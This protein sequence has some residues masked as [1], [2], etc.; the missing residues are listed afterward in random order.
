LVGEKFIVRIDH[1]S[2][3]YF[4]DQKDLNERQEKWVRKI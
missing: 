3:E 1:N 4:L 2:L